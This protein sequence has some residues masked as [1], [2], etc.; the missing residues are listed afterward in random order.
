MKP[1]FS[2]ELDLVATRRAERAIGILR[3]KVNKI[4]FSTKFYQFF[5]LPYFF[6]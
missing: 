6:A 2:A 4:I 1:G 5:F 3:G